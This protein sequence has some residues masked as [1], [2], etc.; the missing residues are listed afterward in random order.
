MQTIQIQNQIQKQKGLK[1]LACFVLLILAGSLILAGCSDGGKIA[2]GN[3]AQQ[4]LEGEAL[5]IPVS[6]VSET[7][8]FYPVTV[9]G[10]SME[11]IAVKASDGTIRTAFNTCQICFNSG[12]GYYK[13]QEDALVCQNCGS[14][15]SMDSVEIEVGGCNP[16]PILPEEKAVTDESVAIPY[17][18]LKAATGIFGNWK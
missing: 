3:N 11:V 12:N 7:A 10:T 2:G 17:D 18:S 4:I 14:W 6:E 13:Q 1:W 15:F 8:S 16:W 5:T 9:D